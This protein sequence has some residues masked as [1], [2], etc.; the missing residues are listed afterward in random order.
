MSA[1][2]LLY[3]KLRRISYQAK[4][5]SAWMRTR[6]KKK[7][8]AS[9]RARRENVPRHILFHFPEKGSGEICLRGTQ[10]EK[11]RLK[12]SSGKIAEH[13]LKGR[14]IYRKSIWRVIDIDGKQVGERMRWM[15]ESREQSWWNFQGKQRIR[16]LQGTIDG[17]FHNTFLEKDVFRTGYAKRKRMLITVRTYLTDILTK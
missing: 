8:V 6:A 11:D 1:C 2:F 10:A 17:S 13:S 3:R 12:I 7:Y 5:R 15:T 9:D 14:S 16:A 4:K